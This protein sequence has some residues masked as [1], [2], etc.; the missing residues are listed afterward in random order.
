MDVVKDDKTGEI[1]EVHCTYDPESRGGNAPD[2]RKV[3][4]TIHWVSADHAVDAEVRLYDHLF[5][6]PNPGADENVDFIEQLNP[7]SLEVLKSC[8]LEPGLANAKPGD[9]FQFL[10]LGYF[11]V[12]SGDSK[13][14]SLVFNRTVTL[15]DT[16]AK[17][18]NKD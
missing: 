8:K 9:M 18:A 3:K 2:G 4:G 7:N 17:I 13:Q 11:C 16:W 15:K 5:T 6:V 12:D 10:R 14:G 1:I